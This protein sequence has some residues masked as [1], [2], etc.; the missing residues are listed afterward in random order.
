MNLGI[1]HLARL[2]RSHGLGVAGAH[3]AGVGQ[4]TVLAWAETAIGRGQPE[5]GRVMDVTLTGEESSA[6]AKALR[7]YLSDLRGEIADT[8]NPAF[9]RELRAER[10]ALESA[11][12]KLDAVPTDETGTATAGGGSVRV[13]HLWWRIER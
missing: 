8:D 4:S 10:E 3:D 11:M 5:E 2:P 6:V 13:V 12:A 7:T 1:A 9:K